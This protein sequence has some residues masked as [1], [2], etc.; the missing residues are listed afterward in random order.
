M[1]MLEAE[2]DVCGVRLYVDVD[3]VGAIH[4]YERLGMGG[5]YRVMELPR[6]L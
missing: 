3:N 2:D 1:T 5:N 4:T 6:R